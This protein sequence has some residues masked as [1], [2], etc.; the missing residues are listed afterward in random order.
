MIS[1]WT[2]T[3]GCGR[4]CQ[5]SIDRSVVLNCPMA[6]VRD[7]LA[8]SPLLN[9][10]L[11]KGPIGNRCEFVGLYVFPFQFPNR[12]LITRTPTVPLFSLYIGIDVFV[13]SSNISLH[14]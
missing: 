9:L 6:G 1:S 3:G 12:K 5:E 4:M 11:S 8:H 7:S 2:P 10:F 14:F 13:C